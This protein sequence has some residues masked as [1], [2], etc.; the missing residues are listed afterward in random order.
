MNHLANLIITVKKRV[1]NH[2]S[3]TWFVRTYFKQIT[4]RFLKYI[5]ILQV[6]EENIQSLIINAYRK[7]AQ[8]HI[9]KDK[10]KSTKWMNCYKI[11]ESTL[12]GPGLSEDHSPA[13]DEGSPVEA[14]SPRS[15]IA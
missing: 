3:R 7:T 13:A 4:N 14:H 9:D 10:G 5:K 2:D 6:L 8:R 15:H 11:L 1:K 12:Y